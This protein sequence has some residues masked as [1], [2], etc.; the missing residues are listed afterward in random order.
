MESVVTGIKESILLFYK[1]ILDDQY[2]RYRSW[3]HCYSCFQ[4]LQSSKSEENVDTATLHLAF[5]LASWGMYRGSS[6]L[7]QKD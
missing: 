5:Y 4:R 2:H 7:L 3:E 6:Q 1:E